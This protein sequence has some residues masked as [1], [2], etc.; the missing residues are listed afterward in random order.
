MDVIQNLI[1]DF[2]QQAVREFGIEAESDDTKAYLIG[3]LAEN[4]SG[5]VLVE[6]SKLIPDDK[7][8][9]FS[10]LTEGSDVDA[11]VHFLMPYIADFQG[12][13][14]TEAQKEIEQTKS[15]MLEESEAAV[16]GGGQ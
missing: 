2:A 13:V 8:A 4:I 12:F 16:T 9:E 6:A 15:Y 3:Q 11:I 7:R 5:R 14:Q 1:G 10:A